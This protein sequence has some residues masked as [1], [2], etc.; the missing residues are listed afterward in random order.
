LVKRLQAERR[1]RERE[2]LF[3]VEGARWLAELD[4]MGWPAREIFCTADWISRE[5]NAELAMRWGGRIAQV[6][7]ALLAEMSDLEQPAGVLAIVEQIALPIPAH[8]TLIVVLDNLRVPGNVGTIARTAA[9]AGVDA[10]LLSPGSVDFYNPKVVR[11]A[12]GAHLRLPAMQTTWSEIEYICGAMVV[13][14][15]AADG[16]R[17][18]AAVD[19][20]VPSVLVIGSEAFGAGEEALRLATGRISIPMAAETES[21]N[22]AIAAAVILFEAAR[23]RRQSAGHES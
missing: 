14:L 4:H 5:E 20:T 13:W 7:D 8:P 1:L 10:L 11:G 3:V 16:E 18:Y 22:A 15:A 21:L 19:W 9:A 2:R 17:E 23:Q 12:M 6:S